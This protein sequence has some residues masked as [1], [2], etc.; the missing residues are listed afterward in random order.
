MAPFAGHGGQE[1]PGISEF[2][3]HNTLRGRGLPE[4]VNEGVLEQPPASTLAEEAPRF[5]IIKPNGFNE[6]FFATPLLSVLS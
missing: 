6:I 5:T 1:S 2:T 3:R 4:R